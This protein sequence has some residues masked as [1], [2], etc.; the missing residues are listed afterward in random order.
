MTRAAIAGS[1]LA[2]A[3]LLAPPASEPA[4]AFCSV[5]DRGPCAPAFCSVFEHG[6]CIPDY[7]FPIGQDLRLTIESREPPPDK[8]DGDLNTLASLFKALRAC[9][10]PPKEDAARAGMEVSVRLSFRKSGEVIG[11]PRW[12]YTTPQVPDEAR[13]LY[14]DAVTASL[15]RCTPLHLTKGLGGAIA[16]RPIA[17][18][19]VD[20]RDLPHEEGRP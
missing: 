17:I 14:R 19:Y 8:P 5:F 12:T 20:N 9:W 16:G 10:V 3:A 11:Q 1:S 2:L 6:V 7:G 13:K 15:S 4:A 18:R